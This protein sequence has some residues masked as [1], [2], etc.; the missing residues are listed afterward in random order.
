MQIVSLRQYGRWKGRSIGRIVCATLVWIIRE[1]C[2]TLLERIGNQVLRSSGNSVQPVTHAFQDRCATFDSSSSVE[3][4]VSRSA[5]LGVDSFRGENGGL[6]DPP[7]CTCASLFGG[8]QFP[9]LLFRQEPHTFIDTTLRV[10]VESVSS[11]L[12]WSLSPSLF[13]PWLGRGR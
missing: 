8:L 2:G 11:H 7:C 4:D 13:V 12:L 3:V 1:V 9:F 5:Q 10:C 6:P